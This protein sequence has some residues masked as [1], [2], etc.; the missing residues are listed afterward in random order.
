[1]SDTAPLPPSEAGQTA[2]D[3]SAT[4]PDRV[5]WLFRDALRRREIHPLMRLVRAYRERRGAPAA[6]A[7]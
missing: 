1:M 5:D 6:T 4:D 7:D 3:A 2:P